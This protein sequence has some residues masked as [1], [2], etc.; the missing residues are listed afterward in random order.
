MENNEFLK[1]CIK[2]RM[3]YCFYDKTKFEDLDSD[4]IS[5]DEK[6]QKNILWHFR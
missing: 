3:C 6:S 4:N 5:Q 2:N 1:V